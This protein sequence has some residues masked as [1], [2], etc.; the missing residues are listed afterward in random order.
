[1]KVFILISAIIELLAGIVLFFMASKVPDLADLG[2][3]NLALLKLYGAAALAMGVFGLT[4]WKNFDNDGMVNSFLVT[5]L[6]FHFGVALAAWNAANVGVLPDMMTTGL[7]TALGLITAYF[8]V[9][10]R[11]A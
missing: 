3:G 9:K 1:M 4:V 8:L 5:F 7:H 10:R 6:V 11:M 2:A